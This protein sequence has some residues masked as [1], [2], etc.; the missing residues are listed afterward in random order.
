MD[1]FT[2]YALAQSGGSAVDS[3]LG[4]FGADAERDRL[5]Q[6]RNELLKGADAA[7]K[8]YQTGYDL[9]NPMYDPYVQA[10]GQAWQQMQDNMGGVLDPSN[11]VLPEMDEF[12]YGKTVDDFLDPSMAY[13]Q[14]Q[15]RRQL[16]SSAAAAGGLLSGKALKDIQTRGQQLA[17]QDYGNAFNR[18]TTDKN[19][20]Y[21]DYLNRFNT[22]RAN[23][24]DRY[25]KFSDK[26]NRLSGVANIGMQGVNA[27]ANLT[28]GLYNNFADLDM[29]RANARAGYHTQAPSNM[30]IFTQGVGGL[31]SGA[32]A[33][34]AYGLSKYNQ[35][36]Q[37]VDPRLGAP[38]AVP[39]TWRG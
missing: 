8:Q 25:S 34:A 14:D 18:M 27:Q 36:T 29:A 23:I 2:A 5:R 6:A 17:M 9:V 33:P 37:P 21:Q 3:V 16:E 15:A 35:P 38:G 30:E 11:F 7:Q 39:S 28:S 26:Y 13:Q 24:Q 22:T 19:F 12:A 10:G 4:M 20:T 1:P 31:V 32:A